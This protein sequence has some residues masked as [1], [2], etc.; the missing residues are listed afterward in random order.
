MPTWKEPDMAMVRVQPTEVA[1]GCDPFTGRPRTVRMGAQIM[2]VARIE[3]VRDESAAYPA[4]LGPRTIFDVR[5]AGQML[6][7]AFQHRSRRWVV[8]GLDVEP[9]VLT[10]AA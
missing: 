7:V 10:L 9:E 4:A 3:R 1:V 5:T 2:P 6:R 8:E